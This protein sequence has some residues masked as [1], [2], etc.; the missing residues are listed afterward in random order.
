MTILV[1][2]SVE[3]YDDYVNY[4]NTSYW[5][6]FF[7]I[8]LRWIPQMCIYLIDTSIWFA[9]W[10]AMAGSIVGFQVMGKRGPGGG[11]AEF[12]VIIDNLG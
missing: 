2:P 9:C 7:L 11:E 6:M 3:I 5:G 12:L 1:L 10:T 4:P 8:L